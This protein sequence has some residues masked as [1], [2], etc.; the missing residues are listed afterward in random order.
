[1][2]DEVSRYWPPYMGIAHGMAKAMTSYAR[3]QIYKCTLQ[4][5]TVLELLTTIFKGSLYKHL[6]LDHITSVLNIIKMI[7]GSP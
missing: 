7:L 1:M 6:Q 5:P 3:L 4:E 2:L